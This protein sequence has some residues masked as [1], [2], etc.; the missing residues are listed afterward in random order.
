MIRASIYCRKSTDDDK[1]AE[2]KSVTRQREE[3]L[4]YAEAQGWVV[5]DAHIFTDDG[6]SGAYGEDRRPGLKALLAAAEQTPH[7]FKGVI[8]AAD[9]RLMREQWKAAMV[10]SRLHEA[11][12]RL[13]YYQERRQVDL[14]SSVG[15][16]MEGMRGFAS[17]FYREAVTRHM[18]DS[19]KRKAHAGH[20]HGGKVFGYTNLRVAGHAEYR[21]HPEQA[22]VVRRIFTEY[23][24]GKGLR[25]IAKLLNAEHL[26][27]PRPSKGG[28]AGWSYITIRDI[29]KRELYIGQVVSRW[30]DGEIRVERPEVRIITDPLWHAVQQRRQQVAAIH[31]RG[32]KGTLGGKPAS[33]IESKYLLTGMGLCPC[34]SGL[35]VRSRSH[36]RKRAYFYTCRAALDKG[37]V[38]ENRMH[39][40]LQLADAAVT[41]YL[42]GVLLHPD[43]VAEAV[44]RVLQPDPEAEPVEQQR[45]R[46]QRELDQVQRELSNLASAVA[47][48]GGQLET[49]LTEI[50]TRERRR[51]DVQAA[52]TALDRATAEPLPDPAQLRQRIDEALKD[53]RGLAAKH[54]QTTRHLLRKLLVG[55]LTFT[56]QPEHGPGVIRF[57][58]EGTLAPLAGM[59][60]I[61]GVQGLVAPTG[62]EPVFQS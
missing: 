45:G 26:P 51:G 35:T 50:K 6:I 47:A 46:L 62:F 21:I 33:S 23:A 27:C 42:E 19:L 12:L 49:V 3:G 20:V 29:V 16:F 15:K 43:V 36:G 11:G 28:P 53:W 56:P 25:E 52:L 14:S 41:T 24:A 13:H 37:T 10:L 18:V 32:T 4:R 54:V 61:P 55:R 57:T 5:D 31:R 48:G 17:E 58:G 44:C 30:Q 34:G 59:L 2:A 7:L 1:H 39:L 9:D 22:P 8:M 38:C 40:P 60:Q